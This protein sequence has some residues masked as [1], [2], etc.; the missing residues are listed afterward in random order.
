MF[1]AR[2]HPGNLWNSEYLT[3]SSLKDH[4]PFL[5]GHRLP[6]KIRKSGVNVSQLQ[7]EP[8]SSDFS[9]AHS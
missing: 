2:N 3:P 8:L 6:L 4:K 7:V 5:C 1:Y 9:G